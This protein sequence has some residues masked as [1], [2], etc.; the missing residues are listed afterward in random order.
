MCARQGLELSMH[1]LACCQEEESSSCSSKPK[2]G[3][4]RVTQESLGGACVTRL[5]VLFIFCVC[6]LSDGK[7]HSDNLKSLV[8]YVSLLS[9]T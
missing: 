6:V 9:G 8:V 4:G 1:L 7:S 3:E 2:R 5:P